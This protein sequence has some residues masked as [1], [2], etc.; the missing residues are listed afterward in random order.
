MGPGR[1]LSERVKFVRLVIDKKTG[2][3]MAGYRGI[4]E[5]AVGAY[6]SMKL[7]RFCIVYTCLTWKMY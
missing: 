5:V 7:A 3:T 1:R 4:I 6:K 2:W